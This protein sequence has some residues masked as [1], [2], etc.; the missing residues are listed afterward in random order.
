MLLW[1]VK[2]AKGDASPRVSPKASVGGLRSLSVLDQSVLDDLLIVEELSVSVRGVNQWQRG[3][4]V[5][6]AA[7]GA[8]FGPNSGGESCNTYTEDISI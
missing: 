5:S 6:T 4:S 1:K 8:C 7:Q 3:Q 2:Q